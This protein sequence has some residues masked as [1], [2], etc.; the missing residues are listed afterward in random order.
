[1]T[2]P[3]DSAID[4]ELARRLLTDAR[5]ALGTHLVLI[6]VAALLIWR[7]ASTALVLV[8]VGGV[9]TAAV[10]RQA[11]VRRLAVVDTAPDAA[12]RVARLSIGAI[13]L[14]WGVGAAAVFPDVPPFHLALLLV[15]I[16]GLVAG[17]AST[18]TAD[19]PA[20]RIFLAAI[21]LPLP[22][23]IL[24]NGQD[25]E[26]WVAVFLVLLFG[27]LM[28]V[29]HARG[30]RALREHLSALS[31][32][33]RE[34]V[35]L[36]ALIA[37]AP[38]AIVIIDPAG[39][40]RRANAR[41]EALFGWPAQEIVGQPVND[42]IVPKSEV[43]KAARLDERVR[44]GEVVTAEVD[45][46]RRDGRLVPVRVSIAR[47]GPAL[48]DDVFTMYE[49]ISDHRR[50]QDA[51]T[52]LASIVESSADAIVG[53]NLDGTITS[54]NAAAE[55]MFGY[56]F[57]EVRGKPINVLVPSDRA[58]EA[59]T[60]LDRIRRGETVEHFE[61]LR[62]GKDGK[63]IPVSLSASVIRDATGR[64]SGFSV[65]ARDVSAQETARRALEE[66]RDAAERAA[67]A[68]SAFLANM[69]HEI[70]TPLNAV[71]GLTELLLD[72]ELSPEQQYSLALVR[73]AG[74][75]LL[76][77]LNDILDL[78]KIEAEHLHLEAVPFD[79]AHLVESTVGLLAV[80]A[81]EKRL[82]L[83]A[84]VA[85]D[86]PHVRGDP[87]RMRQVLTN[88]LGNAIKFTERG[89]V[90]ISVRR[91]AARDGLVPLGFAVRD[92]GIGI[93]ADK[94]ETIFEE[95]SQ[96]DTST[97]RR[98]GGTG[99]GL[100]I[101]RRLVRLMGGEL[102]VTSEVGRGS[103]F[104]FTIQLPLEDAPAD[105]SRPPLA[106][107]R[108]L[109]VDDNA[110]NRRI[111][112]EMLEAAGMQLLEAADV[113]AALTV[114]EQTRGNGA[115]VDVAVIDAQMPE[116][117]GFDL[118]AAV[119]RNPA[120]TDLRLVLLTSTGQ[121]GDAQR[122]RDFGIQGYLTK[123]AS[124]LELLDAIGA[125]LSAAPDVLARR[126]V[127]R[128]SIAESRRNLRI[129]LAEDNPVN[130]QVATTML[131]KRGH[132]VDVVG[133]GRAA[134]DAAASQRYDVVLMD[135]Q[136]P[137]MDGFE[138]TRAIRATPAGRDLPIVALTAHAL[139]GERERCLEAGMTGYV[140]KPFKPHELFA[141]IEGW[142]PAATAM[143]APPA[144]SAPVDL[145]GFRGD[146]RA[147]GAEA[148]A[149][150][151]LDTF[152]ETAGARL[153]ALADADAANDSPALGRAAHAFKSAAGA[154]GAKS[155]AALLT[156]VEAAG[157]GGDLAGARVACARARLEADRV[158]AYLKS[159][160]YSMW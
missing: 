60:I 136:M 110:T 145:E 18:L 112:R 71:L 10:L 98:Y 85:A 101:A 103:T 158:L 67:Q 115:P 122:C 49:D 5:V 77:L 28:L 100:A 117:D 92:T 95:F 51:L 7:Q 66:A 25:R 97:T 11:L 87:T 30:H 118:A 50:A 69:S 91:A 109:V 88:L 144:Q 151:I 111:V 132:T 79:P 82:E 160:D 149:R 126:I 89:E 46:R 80:R 138:A 15:I 57:S 31:L 131:R 128:H 105:D 68:R 142:E 42:L 121:R 24:F 1:M 61:T 129:L 53:Q 130:Q 94:L 9:T 27:A 119:R 12:R 152:V 36:D 59:T 4:K 48:T 34:R 56:S 93:P 159:A 140:P 2:A 137:E 106:G 33:A 43:P 86:V 146:L 83:L 72:T 107:R 63:A 84:D 156:Q 141:T 14:A 114:L 32:L 39:V 143:A 133:T 153:R 155:L 16:A 22:V 29:Q 55:R 38:M 41:F 139:T 52:R 134:V 8:W 148:A 90:V 62:V 47:V 147:A 54:W 81:R 75:T 150:A 157:S 23:G 116:R 70:R 125:V 113:D 135:I 35:S 64:L 17:A 78:S 96:A 20:F 120:H 45:R 26:H 37:G 58:E 73:T 13:A 6:A 44:R 21:L 108:V 19:Q 127:T 40:V 65:I 74:E 123:P 102:T 76:T 3:Q 99:L 104:A 124:R 154:I